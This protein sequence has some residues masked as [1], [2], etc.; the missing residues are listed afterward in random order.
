MSV[1]RFEWLSEPLP[2]EVRASLARLA[3]LDDAAHIAVM[4]DVHLA[5]D[6]CIGTVFA[7][8]K[9]LY[10]RAIG[11]DIGCGVATVHLEG[12]AASA[13]DA[14]IRERILT[15]IARAAPIL[16]HRDRMALP[17]TLDPAALSRPALRR[18]ARRDGAVQL[19]T[20]GR[21]NHFLEL[22]TDDEDGLWLMA[23]T[24]SRG[25]GRA[26]QEAWDWA[27]VEADSEAGRAYLGD[28]EWAEAWA[29]ANR[30]L[31]LEASVRVLAS[32][33]GARPDPDSVVDCSHNHVRAMDLHEAR[34]WV[35]RKGAISARAGEPGLIPGSMGT[36]S[37]HVVGRGHPDSLASSSHGAGRVM[38]RVDARNRIAP[39]EVRRQLEGV[40]YRSRPDLAEEAP[41]AYRSITAVMRAQ[42]TLTRIVRR[43]RPLV[44][45]KR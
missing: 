7:S 28:L 41:G 21:G 23:H 14:P 5:H 42:K 4:P 20:V 26:V 8:R 17:A 37:F 31:L 13:L 10:P 40:T 33:T 29:A 16:R 32:I 35:H 34:V 12:V 24:G 2:V 25:L 38:S 11:S 43:V 15:E 1:R 45:H 30:R 44:V 39:Q 27:P 6:V 36:A 3:R 9:R 19:G 22:Q 18:Q